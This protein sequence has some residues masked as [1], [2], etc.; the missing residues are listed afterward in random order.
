[1]DNLP[2]PPDLTKDFV[3]LGKGDVVIPITDHPK[4]SSVRLRDVLYYKTAK[5]RNIIN[6][7]LLREDYPKFILG[8]MKLDKFHGTGIVH[9]DDPAR[10]ILEVDEFDEQR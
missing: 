5:P 6:L 10:V 2:S 3:V 1:M 7:T 9:V 4:F 8:K